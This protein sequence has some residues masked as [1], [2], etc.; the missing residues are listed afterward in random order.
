MARSVV[1]LLH[2]SSSV[3]LL[4]YCNLDTFWVVLTS[5]LLQTLQYGRSRPGRRSKRALCAVSVLP[6]RNVW[7]CSSRFL[8]CDT[9]HCTVTVWTFWA[10]MRSHDATAFQRQFLYY[11]RACMK[12]IC[13]QTSF[14]KCKVFLSYDDKNHWL[15]DHQKYILACVVSKRLKQEASKDQTKRTQTTQTRVIYTWTGQAA[16]MVVPP[17]RWRHKRMSCNPSPCVLCI[18][19]SP[20]LVFL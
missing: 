7:I 2:H 13:V 3:S 11:H 12:P 6:T 20:C 5:P 4:H 14:Y 10:L 19:F 18:G 15:V 8:W 9:T 1:V 16:A 17:P